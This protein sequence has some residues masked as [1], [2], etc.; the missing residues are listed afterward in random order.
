MNIQE[1]RL[2][3]LIHMEINYSLKESNY[4]NSSIYT[5]HFLFLPINYNR[6]I[7]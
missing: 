1:K 2:R 6:N 7:L 5:Q 4:Q 3:M